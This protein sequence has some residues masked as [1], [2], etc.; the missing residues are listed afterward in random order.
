[1]LN[2]AYACFV[3]FYMRKKGQEREITQYL[4][5]TRWKNLYPEKFNAIWAFAL[6]HAEIIYMC[7]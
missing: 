3:N 2:I 5:A 6:S 7:L 4:L 1:M